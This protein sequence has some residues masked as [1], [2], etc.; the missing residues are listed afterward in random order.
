MKNFVVQLGAANEEEFKNCL[1]TMWTYDEKMKV[2]EVN[3][4]SKEGEWWLLVKT[5]LNFNQLY[6]LKFIT[7]VIE[8]PNTINITW[9]KQFE[10]V[11]SNDIDKIK[12]D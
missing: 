4:I 10:N 5:K 8:M 11:E 2:T 3:C 6:N 1:N 12:E 7:F 9:K